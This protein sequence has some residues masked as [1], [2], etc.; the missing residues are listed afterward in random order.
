MP[1]RESGGDRTSLAARLRGNDEKEIRLQTIMLYFAR[2][3]AIAMVCS[4]ARAS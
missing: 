2:L 1:K 4:S 3:T